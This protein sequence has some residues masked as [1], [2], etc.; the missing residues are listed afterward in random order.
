MTVT[1]IVT[2]RNP[3]FASASEFDNYVTLAQEQTEASFF[4]T[5][6]N[7]AVALR[8]MHMMEMDSRGGTG[9]AIKIEKEGELWR[10][11]AVAVTDQD[12][13]STSY[14]RELKSLMRKWMG[15][16]TRNRMM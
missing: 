15:L 8:V 7:L 11:Y 13:L 2:T 9:G 16:A 14:G 3:A 4:D 6:Y 5:D 1:E 12:L 10:E